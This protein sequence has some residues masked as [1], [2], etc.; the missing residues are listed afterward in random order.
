MYLCKKIEKLNILQYSTCNSYSNKV[1]RRLMTNYAHNIQYLLEYKSI[2]PQNNN[3][4]I[5]TNYNISYI[6]NGNTNFSVKPET[7][8]AS[9]IQQQRNLPAWRYLREAY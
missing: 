3:S 1:K 7:F 8:N 6:S 4:N 5:N 9:G 2:M